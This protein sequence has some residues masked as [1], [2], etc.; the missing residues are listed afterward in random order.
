VG[1]TAA[2]GAEY[3]GLAACFVLEVGLLYALREKIDFQELIG[4]M[5]D[6][7]HAKIYFLFY[8]LIF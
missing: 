2:R 1:I 4:N 7:I 3:M 5:K 8:L 6:E